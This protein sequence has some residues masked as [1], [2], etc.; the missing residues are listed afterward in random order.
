[1]GERKRD[2][3]RG[4]GYW[5][6]R[7]YLGQMIVAVV[8]YLAAR[9]EGPAAHILV[10]VFADFKRGILC[11]TAGVSEDV[12]IEQE[13]ATAWERRDFFREGYGLGLAAVHALTFSR[14]NP[15]RR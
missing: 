9:N 14:G 5:S 4:P 10:D 7:F 6:P 1:M 3:P 8:D 11:G 2:K 12:L 15:E 13:A